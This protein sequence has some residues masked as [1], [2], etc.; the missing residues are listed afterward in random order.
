[1]DFF[2]P[3][4]FPKLTWFFCLVLFSFVL[5]W[6]GVDFLRSFTLSIMSSVNN[7]FTSFQIYMDFILLYFLSYFIL[8]PIALTST[9]NTKL[10]RND[11]NGH[12]CFVIDLTGKALSLS[13]LSM[14]L[15]ASILQVPTYQMENVFFCT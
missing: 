1:M 4:A 15:A 8:V 10:I 11:K 6:R 12:S 2:L 14:M 7:S 3:Y 5:F 9:S 13:L